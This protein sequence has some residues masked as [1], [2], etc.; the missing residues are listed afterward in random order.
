MDFIHPKAALPANSS[1]SKRTTRAHGL[2]MQ[3]S[4]RPPEDLALSSALTHF[5]HQRPPRTERCLIALL[6]IWQ[7]WVARKWRLCICGSLRTGCGAVSEKAFPRSLL[8]LLVKRCLTWLPPLWISTCRTAGSLCFRHRSSA[9][10]E[11]LPW[12]PT[13]CT[14]GLAHGIADKGQ[15]LQQCHNAHGW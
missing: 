1:T 10:V 14:K 8:C 7:P 6:V 9:A 2:R 15:P 12:C 13:H 11:R 5:A 3:E 4:L